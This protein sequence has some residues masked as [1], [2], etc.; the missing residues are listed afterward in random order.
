MELCHLQTTKMATK[1]ATANIREEEKR[2]IVASLLPGHIIQICG[3]PMV[4][5]STLV[6]QVFDE[7]VP[8]H[9]FL[10]HNFTCENN[11]SYH[12][13]LH[14]IAEG[15][16]SD[17][18]SISEVNEDIILSELDATFR[19]S[20]N[21]HHVLVFH[22]C[23]G[24]LRGDARSTGQDTGFLDLL[25]QIISKFSDT[26]KLSVVL[27]SYIRFPLK[28]QNA[29]TIEIGALNFWD[30]VSVLQHYAT[31]SNILPYVSTCLNT[32]PLPGAV[33]LFAE[34]FLSNNSH[35]Q[36]PEVMEEL[37]V[38]DENFLSM[39]FLNKL[40]MVEKWVPPSILT[41]MVHFCHSIGSSFTEEHLQ[42]V[43]SGQTT[44]QWSRVLKY[45]LRKYIVWSFE[46]SGTNRLVVHPLLVY[47]WMQCRCHN[48]LVLQGKW[49]DHSCNRFTDFLCR[50]L[51]STEMNMVEH[52]QKS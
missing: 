35:K 42:C 43:V 26:F 37:L 28:G 45:L 16:G 18:T 38:Q 46:M 48:H 6:K 52:K 17:P 3:P 13:L 34:E 36:P 23:Q 4:G 19:K 8:E 31:D 10:C 2:N 30:I 24:F 51:R 39:V 15:L 41:S 14:V 20:R 7:C 50:L 5:K 29:S 1:E 32:I 9:S 21:S 11:Y 33:R 22:K 44:L 40:D 25:R 49:Y 47:Y 12:D 27:T